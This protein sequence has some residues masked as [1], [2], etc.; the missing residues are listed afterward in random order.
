MSR[1]SVFDE[2]GTLEETVLG[3]ASSVY[4]PGP[5]PIEAESRRSLGERL[6]KA[7]LYGLAGGL[8]VPDFLRRRYVRE[9]DAFAEVLDRHGVKIL[10]PDDVHP[11]SDEPLGLGQM[12]SRD[13]LMAVGSDLIE[14][15]LQIGMRRKENRGLHPRIATLAGEG[16]AVSTLADEDACLEGGD[17]VVDWPYVY[18]GIGRYASN[19]AGATWLQQRLGSRAQVVPVRLREASIL[20]LD[21][22]MTLTGPGRGI[23]HRPALQDPLP[24]PLNRYDFIDI[25]AETRR[26]MGG[27]ILM[28]DPETIVVQRRHTALAEA[29]TARGLKVAPVGFTAHADLEGAFRC[30]T[31]PLRRR[32]DG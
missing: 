27:N 10:R 22:C 8:R 24:E 26:Q 19:L 16:A 32:R 25:D 21:C 5:H 31:A 9:L 18:V 7:T 14:G 1:I 11:T 17:V 23:I 30:A 3:T 13:P 4:F 2:W 15:R 28:L 12:F 6:F 29:L 20:H